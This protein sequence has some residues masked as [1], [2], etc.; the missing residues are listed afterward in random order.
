[1]FELKL[2]LKPKGAREAAKSL[3][4]ELADAIADGRL[5]AGARL[6]PSRKSTVFFGVSRNTAAEVYER[7][8]ASGHAVSRHG[9]GTYVAETKALRPA[10]AQL[11]QTT[12]KSRLNEFWL[13]PRGHRRDELLARCVG[14]GRCSKGGARRFPP[15]DG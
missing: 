7:L 1:L 9:A 8:V 3:Y 14:C 10:A 13:R 15:S 2:N 6:P 5:T 11:T 4:Q 12:L